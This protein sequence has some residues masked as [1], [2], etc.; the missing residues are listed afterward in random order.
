MLILRN[1]YPS[2]KFLG[3]DSFF[4]F[5][6]ASVKGYR[7]MSGFAFSLLYRRCSKLVGCI[8]RAIMRPSLF[9]ITQAPPLS[10]IMPWKQE[11]LEPLALASPVTAS[12]QIILVVV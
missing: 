2:L 6:M 10:H 12:P 8:R 5:S 11:S 7:V 3:G 4:A 9:E 1:A